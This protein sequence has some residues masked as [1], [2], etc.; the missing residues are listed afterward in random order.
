MCIQQ[1][2]NI[3][4]FQSIAYQIY[5]YFFVYIMT[6]PSVNMISV[7]ENAFLSFVLSLRK[8][9]FVSPILFFYSFFIFITQRVAY[10]NISQ[11]FLCI[12]EKVRR[13][14]SYHYF[15][16]GKKNNMYIHMDVVLVIH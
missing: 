9:I 4:L 10:T 16:M 6:L 1:E 2:K 12:Y 15:A 3:N 13:L 11:Y 7:M 14:L 5:T 8:Y